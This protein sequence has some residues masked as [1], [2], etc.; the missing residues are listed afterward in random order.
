M[1]WSFQS[2]LTNHLVNLRSVSDDDSVWEVD[3][4]SYLQYNLTNQSFPT[5]LLELTGSVTDEYGNASYGN[6]QPMA[7]IGGRTPS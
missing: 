7:L 2:Y 4:T 3:M 1:S 6:D 5:C